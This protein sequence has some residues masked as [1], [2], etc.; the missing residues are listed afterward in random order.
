MHYDHDVIIGDFSNARLYDLTNYP[1]TLDPSVQ[2]K[3]RL[4]DFFE[5]QDNSE[6]IPQPA[7]IKRQEV[8]GIRDEIANQN[9]AIRFK[10]VLFTDKCPLHQPGITSSFELDIASVK[11]VYV[12]EMSFRIIDYF[13]D[14]FLWAITESDPYAKIDA[15]GN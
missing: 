15:H 1:L 13:F 3:A 12:F 10:S 9:N 11:I 6:F 14:K 8:I 5:N 7:I 4:S 2:P